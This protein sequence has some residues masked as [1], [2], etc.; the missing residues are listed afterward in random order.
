[1]VRALDRGEF[2]W[3]ELVEQNKPGLSS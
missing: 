1:L 3:R 2:G